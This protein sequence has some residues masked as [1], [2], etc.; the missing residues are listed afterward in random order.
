MK[1]LAFFVAIVFA[2]GGCQSNS[3]MVAPIGDQTSVSNVRDGLQ[4]TFSIPK[5]ILGIHDTLNAFMTVYNQ[6]AR[7]ETALI[8]NI[9]GLF[10]WSLKNERGRVIMFG[11]LAFSQLVGR[12][13]IGP[14]ESKQ[15]FG[16]YR[17]PIADTSGMPVLPGHY[18]LQSTLYNNSMSFSLGLTL[19]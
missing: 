8:G 10:S 2:I 3:N 16:I 11:P 13:P 18:L 17:Q 14:Q 9:Y 19:Q 15:I 1:N 5:P 12:V 6:S 7:P 4:Y